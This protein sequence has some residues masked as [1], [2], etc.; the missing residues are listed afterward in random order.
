MITIL[1]MFGN[2]FYGFLSICAVLVIWT[3]DINTLPELFFTLF[4]IFVFGGFFF[5]AVRETISNAKQGIW[6]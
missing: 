6:I 1:L 3:G 2:I 5:T 4:S